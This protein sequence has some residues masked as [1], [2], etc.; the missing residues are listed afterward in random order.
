MKCPLCDSSMELN[1]I[2]IDKSHK[3]LKCINC[4]FVIF[5]RG[6]PELD[7]EAV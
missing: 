6:I 5:F 7:S 2:N 3:A 1:K 4:H